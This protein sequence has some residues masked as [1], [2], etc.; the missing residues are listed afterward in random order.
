MLVVVE[1]MA[2]SGIGGDIG[3]GNVTG[4]PLHRAETHTT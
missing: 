3:V 2:S 1:S 4:I